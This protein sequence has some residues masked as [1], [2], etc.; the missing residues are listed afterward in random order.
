MD[1]N[2]IVFAIPAFFVLMGVELL[3]NRLRRGTTDYRF[4]DSITNL[5][6]GIGQQVLGGF[7]GLLGVVAYALVWTHARVASIGTGSVAGWVAAFI[8]VDLGYYVFH[9]ASH[10][11]NFFWAAHAV[12]HQSEEYNLS[13]ALRQSWLDPALEWVFYVPLAVAGFP[14]VMF[15]TTSLL[16]TLYQFWIHTRAID[17]LGPLEWVLNTPMAHRVHHAVNPRYLDRNY[18][19]VFVIWDRLF[20]TYVPET[21]PPVYGAVKPLA[22]FNPLWANVQVW[23]VMWRM[24]RE[25]KRI[26]DKVRVWIAPPEWRPADLGGPVTIPEATPEAQVKYD[27][28]AS[29]RTIAWVAANYVLLL[30]AT[31]AFLWF[32]GRMTIAE[33]LGAIALILTT[34]VTCGALVEHKRWALPLEA[35]R[36]AAVAGAACVV[37]LQVR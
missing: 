26:G 37:L 29:R 34:V 19:G 9:R 30:A 6:C 4:A 13:V 18:A 23:T 33:R 10:R 1:V 21:E 24:A 15:V 7:L 25:T 14:P 16:N 35:A 12:H 8:A 2:Y 3:V 22:S 31:T 27:V 20:G 32:E 5:S 11:I 36:I 17:T 28:R